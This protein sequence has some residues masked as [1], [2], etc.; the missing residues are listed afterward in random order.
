MLTL[1]SMPFYVIWIIY[2]FRYQLFLDMYNFIQP[3]SMKTMIIKGKS[4]NYIT[5]FRKPLDL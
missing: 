1:L 2:G 4:N 5:Y 3:K